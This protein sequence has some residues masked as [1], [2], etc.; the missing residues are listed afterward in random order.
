MSEDLNG[1]IPQNNYPNQT[2]QNNYQAPQN[3]Y[4]NQ[5]P[6]GDMPSQGFYLF[7]VI[8]GFLCGILWGALSLGP[9]N[10]M[11]AAIAAND[12]VEAKANAKKI[13][14]FIIIGIVINVL[15]IIGKLAQ[16]GVI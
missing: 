6:Q 3:N 9:Y 2:P 5:M 13:R 1:N 8:V 11:K 4:P 14:T 16:E 7:L 15:L 10:K 12:S